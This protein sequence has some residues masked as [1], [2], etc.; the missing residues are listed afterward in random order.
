MS[1]LDSIKELRDLKKAEIYGVVIIAGLNMTA[2]IKA[3]SYIDKFGVTNLFLFV[4][5]LQACTIP[6]YVYLFR[7]YEVRLGL[8]DIHEAARNTDKLMERTNELSK[9]TAEALKSTLQT[10]STYRCPLQKKD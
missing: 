9:I 5:L 10:A 4:F 3:I 2:V 7:L 1:I 8:D 6:L